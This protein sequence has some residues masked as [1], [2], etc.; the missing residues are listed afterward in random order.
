MKY[1]R[2]SQN[3][4]EE[5]CIPDMSMTTLEIS[6]MIF[7]G[8]MEGW[9]RAGGCNVCSSTCLVL[10]LCCLPLIAKF[11]FSAHKWSNFFSSVWLAIT[12][13][14]SL[15]IIL[16][17][18]EH[19]R[20]EIQLLLLTLKIQRCCIFRWFI[21]VPFRRSSINMGT[22]YAYLNKSVFSSL[23]RGLASLEI[24]LLPYQI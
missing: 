3:T 24:A 11:C 15:H 9:Q 4:P 1:G 18:M 5:S 22:A 21:F 12:N 6:R 14:S 16:I 10:E 20:K 17:L 23:Q 13:L 19:S 7:P 8:R 2:V